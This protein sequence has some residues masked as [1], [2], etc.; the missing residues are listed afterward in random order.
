M[1]KW[2]LQSLGAGIF[3]FAGVLGLWAQENLLSIQKP[4]QSWSYIDATGKVRLEGPYKAADD[5]SQG[6][7]RISLNDTTTA[8]INL[9]GKVVFTINTPFNLTGNFADD[10]AWFVQ[11]G[12]MGFVD[13]T[14][15]VV[16]PPQFVPEADTSQQSNQPYLPAYF[17]DGLVPARQP[18]SVGWVKAD[19]T[20]VPAPVKDVTVDGTALSADFSSIHSFSEGLAAYNDGKSWGYL[21]ADGKTVLAPRWR[22]A[23]P[24]SDGLALV[25][26]ANA[27]GYIDKEGHPAFSQQFEQARDFHGNRAAVKLHDG[28]A[29]I[30]TQGKIITRGWQ[31]LALA[32]DTQRA[33]VKD[34][35]YV[36]QKDGKRGLVDSNGQLL[37]KPVWDQVYAFVG[38]TAIVVSNNLYGLVD[39]QGKTVLDPKWDEIGYE[40]D[41]RI[42]FSQDKK[43][44]WLDASGQ[45]VQP[46][47][48]VWAGDFQHGLAP[49]FD[50]KHGGMVDLS[51]KLVVP[52]IYQEIGNL[53]DGLRIMKIGGKMGAL[54]ENGNVAVPA[55]YDAIQDFSEGT[56]WVSQNGEVFRIDTHG[57]R[58]TSGHW[59]YA[60]PALSG[61]PVLVASGG[62]M[63]FLNT[64]GQWAI[65][66]VWDRALGFADGKALVALRNERGN[67]WYYTDA[68]GKVLFADQEWSPFGLFRENRAFVLISRDSE[69]FHLGLVDQEGKLLATGFRA[70]LGGFHN[71]KAAVAFDYGTWGFVDPQGKRLFDGKS[72]QRT[73]PYAEGLAT[74]IQDG[75]FGFI[76]ENGQ[77]AI[78]ARFDRAGLFS[79]GLAWVEENGKDEYVDK[80][81]QVVWSQPTP[82][83]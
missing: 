79:G 53:K 60:A 40:R 25:L 50:G 20:W 22:E 83:A 52:L 9:K 13:K 56:S 8:F 59:N 43:W 39:R 65:A 17:S 34:P 33:L 72:W 73:Y 30:D 58:L 51:G 14:G 7:G 12:R 57:K 61:Q 26:G 74:V 78:P 66:P 64:D 45:V 49:V 23:R 19:G 80:T 38:K 24:F 4:D 10:R 68:T 29:L 70:A 28:W 37:G 27:W 32:E 3:F 82:E 6:L 54:D 18:L 35:I 21:N 47:V 44:G 41:G 11:N 42:A 2:L 15:K 5:F 36:Y 76:D 77:W 63:G 31:D 67:R 81:G 71:G 62:R 75:K 69:G 55:V 48:W 16:I 1:K 46:P